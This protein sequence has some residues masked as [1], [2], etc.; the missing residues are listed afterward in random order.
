MKSDWAYSGYRKSTGQLSL[1]WS[2]IL[3]LAP[4][5]FSKLSPFRS[6]LRPSE[7]ESSSSL[8]AS[9]TSLMF[10]AWGK[11]KHTEN[12]LCGRMQT[13]FTRTGKPQHCKLPDSSSLSRKPSTC[14]HHFFN[15]TSLDIYHNRDKLDMVP[16][17]KTLLM[18]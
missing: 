13:H 5:G 3:S 16:V 15:S 6:S 17:L 11:N 18:V 14:R 12:L 2:S 4:E 10:L 8:A 9:E 1:P 7:A